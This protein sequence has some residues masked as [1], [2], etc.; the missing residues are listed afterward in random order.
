MSD[1][2]RVGNFFGSFDY[3]SVIDQLTYARQA[4]IRSLDSK[5]S[6]IAK[7]KGTI[8]QLVT[9]FSALLSRAKTLTAASS[10]SGKTASVSGAGLT[11]AASP[12]AVPGSFTVSVAQLATGTAVTTNALSAPLNSAALLKDANFATKVTAGTF[13]LKAATGAALSLT[14]EPETQSLDDVVAAINAQTG[15]TGITASLVN[16]TNGRLNILKLDSTLGAIRAGDGADTSNFLSATNLIASPGADSRQ[17]TLG[18]ARLAANAALASAGLNGGS[19]A[20]GAHSFTING[21]SIDY[22]ASTDS[23]NTIINRINTSTAGVKAYYDSVSDQLKLTQSKL[24]SIGISMADDGAGGNFLA[25]TGLAGAAQTLGQNAQYSVDGGPAQYANS[26]TVSLPNGVTLSLTAATAAPV[27]VTVAQDTNSATAA[28]QSFVTDFNSLLQGLND[29][30]RSD[31]DN[32]GPFSGDSALVALRSSLRSII[33]GAGS[34]ITGKYNTLASLG[35]SFGAIGTAAGQANTLVFDQAK[36]TAAL[37]AD[38]L[39]V[40]NALGQLT[41]AS[42]LNGVGSITSTSGAYTGSMPGT[43]T[44]TDDGAGNITSVFQPSNGGASVTTTAVVAPGDA[45]TTLVPGLTLTFGA[46]QAGSQT[47]SVTA[48]SKSVLQQLKDFLE[49]QVG[50]NG[51]LSKRTDEFTAVSKD[52]DERK[53]KIQSSIDAE[54]SLLRNKFIAMEQAQARAQSIMQSLQAAMAQM[55]PK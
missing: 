8:G 46:L 40:Q 23:L 51:S 50:V 54:M 30:T 45:N 43:Y 44:V 55:N 42:A 22:D 19:V 24:G 28:I 12:N 17:S 38:P 29:A 41:F 39:S 31:K 37:Q 18:I 16:D 26:N 21:V 6:L 34:N 53:A 3:Q 2:I 1:P 27:T 36:F 9:Q 25:I 5:A 35:L 15:T 4:P 47:I 20:G 14:V 52:I 32:P 13:T 33:G 7:R 49:G 48:D 11:A 10:V